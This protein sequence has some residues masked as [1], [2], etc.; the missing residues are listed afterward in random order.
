[1]TIHYEGRALEGRGQRDGWWAWILR[2]WRGMIETRRA[3]RLLSAADDDMLKDIGVS[4][5]DID[6]L[7]LHG[8]MPKKSR[9]ES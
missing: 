4:R 1:M 7:V 9:E 8:R 2:R 5:C 6:R 3:L